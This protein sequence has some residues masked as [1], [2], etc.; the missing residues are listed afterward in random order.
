[1]SGRN[2][3]C[4]DVDMLVASNVVLGNFK[5][6]KDQLIPRRKTWA[7]P[8]AAELEGRIGNALDI[9]G[10]NTRID[11]TDTTRELVSKQS[12]TL[13]DLASF[14]IQLEVDFDDDP[15]K[16]KEIENKL[17]FSRYYNKAR[18]DQQE[19]LIQLLSTFKE[20]MSPALR[21]EIEDAGIDGELIDQLIAMRDEINAL[22]V[23]QESLKA[24][25][26]KDTALN[27]EEL[28]AIYKQVIGI[29]KIAPRLLSEVPTASEDFSFTKILSR[30]N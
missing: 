26:P 7:D 28:N 25:A 22:N 5:K 18:N 11:Q 12:E 21:Q 1:M 24:S 20:N 2:Y 16:L 29:C 10:V 19:A 17:G 8:F 27:L 3:N 15:Q 14:K 30:L 4:K 9:L 6:N 23:R 13:A